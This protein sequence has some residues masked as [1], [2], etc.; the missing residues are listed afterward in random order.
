MKFRRFTNWLKKYWILF[1]ILGIIVAFVLWSFYS[2]NFQDLNAQDWTNFL[3]WLGVADYTSPRIDPDR[4][5]QRG[6]T[7]WDVLDLIIVPLTLLMVVRY[8]NQV[9]RKRDEKVTLER[10]QDI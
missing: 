1:G 9:E 4:V 10:N 7:F 6:K 3:M 5:F 8:F 2:R